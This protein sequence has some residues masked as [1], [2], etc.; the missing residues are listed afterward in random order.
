MVRYGTAGP[1][2]TSLIRTRVAM[3]FSLQS[4][5][6]ETEEQKKNASTPA[7]MSVGMSGKLRCGFTFERTFTDLRR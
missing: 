6:G 7:Y 3:V 2:A 5:L 4:W 1:A